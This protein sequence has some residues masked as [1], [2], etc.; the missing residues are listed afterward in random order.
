MR[1]H[2]ITSIQISQFPC[3]YK[4]SSLVETSIGCF[5]NAAYPEYSLNR[6]SIQVGEGDLYFVSDPVIQR[7][8]GDQQSVSVQYLVSELFFQ[9]SGEFLIRLK[10]LIS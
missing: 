10:P 2:L 7:L 5:I 3:I 8:P 1:Q 6:V 9:C 4:H